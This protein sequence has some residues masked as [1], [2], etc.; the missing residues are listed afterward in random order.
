MKNLIKTVRYFIIRKILTDRELS[1]LNSALH[2]YAVVVT[3][4]QK[5]LPDNLQDP[6]YKHISKQQYID[7]TMEDIDTLTDLMGIIKQ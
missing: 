6:I 1:N 2:E 7:R 5:N 3:S 4:F